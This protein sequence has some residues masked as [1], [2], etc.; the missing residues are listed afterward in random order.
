MRE[1]NEHLKNS[2]NIPDANQQI[3]NWP[4]RNV[5][6]GR[7]LTLVNSW[8]LGL[9]ESQTMW[10]EYVGLLSEGV[11][12]KST[13]R[14][15]IQNV[16]TRGDI[17]EIGKIKYVDFAKYEMSMYEAHQACERAFIKDLKYSPEREVRI[18]TM[19]LKHQYCVNMQGRQFTQEECS[20]T[21]M[22]NFDQDGLYILINFVG[23]VSSIVMSPYSSEWTKNLV[24]RVLEMSKLNISVEYSKLI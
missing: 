21:N 19:S 7:E 12:I 24:S 22:N 14:R 13:I 2:F 17:S 11:A 18:S 1:K 10:D 6:D 5:D 23:L 3:D 4:N 15:L 9:E 16:C 8:F 20:G